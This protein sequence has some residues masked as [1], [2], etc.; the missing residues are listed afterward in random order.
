MAIGAPI[1]KRRGDH[2]GAQLRVHL[3]SDSSNDPEAIWASIWKRF[4]VIRAGEIPYEYIEVYRN[5]LVLMILG[6]K[7][8]TP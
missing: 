7:R 8:D 3:G 6:L 4:W 5:G 1:R 2:L